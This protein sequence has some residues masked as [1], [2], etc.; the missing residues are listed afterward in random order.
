MSRS[1]SLPLSTRLTMPRTARSLLAVAIVLSSVAAGTIPKR[2]DDTEE[3]DGTETPTTVIY[4]SKTHKSTLPSHTSHTV[5]A[6]ATSSV[7]H[8]SSNNS[9]V[10]SKIAGIC[11]PLV[12]LLALFVSPALS[13]LTTSGAAPRVDRKARPDDEGGT[14]WNACAR[15]CTP[16]ICGEKRK[17]APL[18]PNA[19]RRV[20]TALLTSYTCSLA[21]VELVATIL[22]QY[23]TLLLE[24]TRSCSCR[25]GILPCLLKY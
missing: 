16:E 15:R 9:H 11:I 22:C 17:V 18:Q 8:P 10:G 6:A 1:S 7:S 19:R 5:V 20:Q 23:T 2:Q 4:P 25:E 14:T 12:F 3:P 21:S 24:P 13:P